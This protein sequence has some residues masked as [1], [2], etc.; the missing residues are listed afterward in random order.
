[1]IENEELYFNPGET[2]IPMELNEGDMEYESDEE[3]E[4]GTGDSW[5]FSNKIKKRL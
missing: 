3:Q 1:M 2:N 4:F 5:R